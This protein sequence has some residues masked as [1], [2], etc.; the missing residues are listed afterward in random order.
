MGTNI[1]HVIYLIIYR[2]I[3]FGKSSGIKLSKVNLMSMALYDTL[4]NEM[5]DPKF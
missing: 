5:L 4:F 1:D 2:D 3:N